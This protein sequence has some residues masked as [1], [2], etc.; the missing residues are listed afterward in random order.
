MPAQHVTLLS[1]SATDA[2]S[3]VLDLHGF[4]KGPMVDVIISVVAA[5]RLQHSLDGINYVDL[6][7]IRS[8][9]AFELDPRGGFYRFLAS[10][11]TGTVTI[12]SG[13]GEAMGIPAL[14][15]T[16]LAATGGP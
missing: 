14:P 15:T 16:P 1:T 8:T 13:M 9:D 5:V 11:N 4:T 3:S 6:R 2:T 7:T 12:I 10:N